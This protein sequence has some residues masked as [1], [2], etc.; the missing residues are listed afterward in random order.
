MEMFSSGTGETTKIGYLNRHHQL[1]TG[2]RGK[3]GTDH[4]QFAYRIACMHAAC[5]AVYGANGADIFQRR[6]PNCQQGAPGLEY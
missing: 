4:L 2:H 3:P 5:G 1:C 6:C